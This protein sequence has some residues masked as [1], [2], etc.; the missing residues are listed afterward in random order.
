MLTV[1]NCYT[2]M[3]LP[4]TATMSTAEDILQR[5]PTAPPPAMAEVVA[6]PHD[7]ERDADDVDERHG[8]GLLAAEDAEAGVVELESGGKHA[9]HE[10]DWSLPDYSAHV[11][12]ELQ[13]VN[14]NCIKSNRICDYFWVK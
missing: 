3:F 6:Q 5:S 10:V 9:W 8:A 12:A 14:P 11:M 2:C 1:V 13:K 4:T 7:E